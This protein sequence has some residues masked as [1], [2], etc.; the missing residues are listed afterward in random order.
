MLNKYNVQCQGSKDKVY[1]G[2]WDTL[3]DKTSLL[4]TKDIIPT[5]L[6]SIISPVTSQDGFHF[7]VF[8]IEPAY[9]LPSI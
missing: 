4:R 8:N 2:P 7:K 3:F 6:L 5:Y 1:N 9:F